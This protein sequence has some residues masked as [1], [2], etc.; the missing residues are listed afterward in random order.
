MIEELE[1]LS[2][3]VEEYKNK[4]MVYIENT[5][6]KSITGELK[7]LKWVEKRLNEIIEDRKNG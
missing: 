1:N 7:A 3:D 5:I 4:T 2:K 6:D